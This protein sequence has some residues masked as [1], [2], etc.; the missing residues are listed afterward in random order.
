MEKESN[1]TE[2]GVRIQSNYKRSPTAPGFSR[3]IKSKLYPIDQ[4]ST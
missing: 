2:R 3:A 4:I 1:Q